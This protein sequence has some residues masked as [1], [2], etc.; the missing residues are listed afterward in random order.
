MKKLLVLTLVLGMASMAS[1]GLVITSDG[2]SVLDPTGA[3][4][5]TSVD[6]GIASDADML[7][8]STVAWAL[9]V[10]DSAGSL[11]GGDPITILSVSNTVIGDTTNPSLTVPDGLSGYF[12][13]I[14][15]GFVTSPV[16]AQSLYEA[17]VFTCDAADVEAVIQLYSLVDLGGDQYELGQMLDSVTIQQVPEPMTMA[18]LGLGGLFLRRRK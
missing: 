16:P 8:F 13:S 3:T 18:L 1:A 5:P 15:V 7:A 17:F 14:F 2:T 11:S 12:G 10:N 9:V 4:A 6:L